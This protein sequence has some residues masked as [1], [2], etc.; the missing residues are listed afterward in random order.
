MCKKKYNLSLK[1]SK[2]FKD[3]IKNKRNVLDETFYNY[4]R[5]NNIRIIKVQDYKNYLEKIKIAENWHG[6]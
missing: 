1:F 5:V 4:C 6:I 2:E 3:F